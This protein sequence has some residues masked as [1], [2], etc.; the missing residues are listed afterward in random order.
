MSIIVPASG[1]E[2]S[3][4]LIIGEA[5]GKNESEQLKPFVGRSG[6]ELERLLSRHGLSSSSWRKTNVV[7]EYFE[8]NPDPTPALIHKW[9]NH[10]LQEIETCNPKL[11]IPVGRFAAKWFLGE[12]AELETVRGLPR[13]AV[14]DPFD[15]AYPD[16]LDSAIVIPVTHPA[17]GL[18]E[19]EAGENLKRAQLSWDFTSLSYYVKLLKQKQFSK[20]ESLIVSNSDPYPDYRDVTGEELRSIILEFQKHHDLSELSIDTEGDP[21]DPWSIQISLIPGTGYTL[22]CAQDDFSVGISTLQQLSDSEV[23]FIMHCAS[24]PGGCMYDILMPRVMGLDLSRAKIIDTMYILYLLRLEA[25]GLKPAS[26]RWCDMTLSP[27]ME[28]IGDIGKE[29]QLKY[30]EKVVNLKLPKPE[31]MIIDENDGTQRLYS[32]NSLSSL[33]NG[34]LNDVLSGKET[35]EGPTDPLKRWKSIEKYLRQ[36]AES[37]LGRIPVGTLADLPLKDAVQ[38]ASTDPDATFRLKNRLLSELERLDLLHTSALGMENLPTFEIM[39]YHGMPASRSR[40]SNLQS[41]MQRKCA[42]LQHKLSVEHYNGKPINPQSTK[43][44]ASLLRRRGLTGNKKTPTGAISTGK[45]SI[46]HLRYKDE[47]IKLV[48]DWREHFH[49][50]KNF[51][52]PYLEAIP[53]DKELHNVTSILKPADT[54]TRRLAGEDPNPLNTPTR[55]EIGRMVRDCFIA[56]EGFLFLGADLSQIELRVLASLSG[57]KFL[58][59]AFL[60]NEDIHTRTAAEVNGISV[61]EV[62]A[63]KANKEKYRTPAKTTNFG[64]V[65]GQGDQGLYDELNRLGIEGW[66]L[67]SCKKLRKEILRLFGIDQWTAQV[68]A[69][70]MKLDLVR[71]LGGMYRYLPNLR[72][73]DNRLIAEAGRHAVSQKVQGTAQTM[74][75]NSMAKLKPEIWNLQDN[76]FL[77]WWL[78][79]YHDELIFLIEGAIAELVMEIVINAMTKHSGIKLKVPVLAEGHIAKEW[80]KLK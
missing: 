47:A 54:H 12:S 57:S 39:Q 68:V 30:L 46:E 23:T 31:P 17:A 62:E 78:L 76:G 1:P 33:A 40:F 36:P 9:R 71:D 28:L 67:L 37:L 44:T 41:L 63:S 53:A 4:I 7:P 50:D 61:E 19:D 56:P 73:S 29:K 32:P 21:D 2:Q 16:C 8:G 75:Q 3:D 59:N 79:Q 64:I 34:I 22:R 70:A 42:E 80:G 35:K 58:I 49:I 55:T 65:Y 26:L 15:P 20:L 48:F 74:I 45:K 6:R 51:C 66:D 77:I 72:S 13:R 14:F 11:I 18:Y 10:L 69:D 60:N 24:T 43:Q 27:Y 52:V 25:R 5:P 38:Y